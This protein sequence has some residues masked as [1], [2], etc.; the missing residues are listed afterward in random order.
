MKR[1]LK[2]QAGQTDLIFIGYQLYTEGFYHN[3]ENRKQL[4][5]ARMCTYL[6]S[7]MVMF[8]TQI[9]FIQHIV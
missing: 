6:A 7:I 1:I 9:Y 8:F 2:G 3:D 5:H 4:N